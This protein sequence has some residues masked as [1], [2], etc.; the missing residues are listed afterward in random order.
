MTAAASP[1]QSASSNTGSEALRR[2]VR[3]LG[4]ELGT[5][6][7]ELG[8]PG[9]FERVEDIRAVSRARRD[10][11]PGAE[12]RLRSILAGLSSEEAGDLIRALTCFFD[13]ANL[14]EDRHRIRVLRDRER[15]R[16]PESRKE[17][18]GDALD[19]LKA[20]GL[21]GARARDLLNRID[22]DL[23]FTAHPTEAKRRTVRATLRRLR[24]DLV[25]LEN[26]D[27]LQR[28]R[29]R[30]L[31]RIRTDLACL[32]ETDSL[33]PTKPTVLDEVDRSLF[34]ADALWR[35][36]PDLTAS[37]RRALRRVFPDEDPGQGSV[38][39]FL[40]FGSWIGGDRD[41][42]PFVT[43]DVTR[44]TLLRLRRAAIEHH[45]RD[46]AELLGT[47]TI[48]N[49]YHAVSPELEQ[50]IADAR[51]AHPDLAEY[52][53]T[54]H[55]AER[56][57]HFLRVVRYRLRL[58]LE[59]DPFAELPDGAYANGDALADDLRLIADSLR[60]N[61]HA[62]LAGQTVQ[63]WIDRAAVFG[64]HLAKLDIRE[65]SSQL[66]D[67]IAQ[68]FATLDPSVSYTTADE[69]ARQTLLTQPIDPVAA[70]SIDHS[71]LDERNRETLALFELIHRVASQGGVGSLGI[72]IVSMT[73]H[74][75][76]VLAVHFLA[77]VAAARLADPQDAAALTRGSWLPT[78]PLFETIDDL[79]RSVET[80]TALLDQPDYAAALRRHGNRQHVMVGYSD[81]TKDGGYLAAN[82]ELFDAQQ[83]LA[84][85]TERRGVELVV[86]HG[87]GGSLGRGGGPA[88]RGILSL[89]PDSVGGRIRI[90]EQGE[91]LAERY[92]DP[93]IARRHLEQVSYATL[94]V[95]GEAAEPIPADWRVFVAAAAEAS[96]RAYRRLITDPAFIA[97]F[98]QA[99]PIDTIEDLP[100]GSRPARRRAAERQLSSLRAIPYTFA[101]TQNRSL[102]TGFF[103]MGYGLVHAA[104]NG[105]ADAADACDWT[106][107]RRMYADWPF[108][109]AMID[110]AEL[111]L[112]K[113]DLPIT[114][115]YAELTEDPSVGECVLRLLT[116]EHA[117]A[118]ATVLAVTQRDELLADTPWLASSI[119]VRNRYVDP[120]NYLQAEL[121]QRRRRSTDEDEQHQ[122]DHL[123]RMAVQGVAAGLRTTG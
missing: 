36:A 84:E 122:I 66:H 52:L 71:T 42:N 109:R 73:H 34:V 51:A 1:D 9:T 74:P 89:P 120:L 90:T 118:R 72:F 75:S 94:R 93:E 28:E 32:W 96:R 29:D 70:R 114:R 104:S 113:A 78:A 18:I 4:H 56:Y 87:R 91:V 110:N 79:Q 11:E 57:R 53:D 46:C 6:L 45:L 10:G 12:E 49:A 38:Q 98:S 50:A 100:I 15:Q 86:F 25:G 22:I 115:R 54:T 60:R 106:I 97:F 16:Y 68:L 63:A 41:G 88:A 3:M 39:P 31:H 102:I 17:S 95:S 44:Q 30:L 55:P 121:M 5:V 119:Q 85:L 23:V 48:S 35:V 105:K 37:A 67:T 59:A 65:D 58:T 76:D 69:T 27:L 77:R 47:L 82:V 20:A 13:L 92:D 117:T 62:D 101:W 103:G 40:R 24:D 2:D 33:R 99:T 43:A 14:A 107:C 64:L 112:A 61:D 80:L 116:E 8:R 111:A 81:S 26:P 123:M 7:R 83:R 108:F 21:S 19:R